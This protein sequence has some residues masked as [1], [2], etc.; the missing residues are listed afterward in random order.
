MKSPSMMV[1]FR[2]CW[3]ILFAILYFLFW[4]LLFFFLYT[5]LFKVSV[6]TH[7]LRCASMLM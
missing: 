7:W 1:M 5:M 4:D 6:F 3:T 2:C